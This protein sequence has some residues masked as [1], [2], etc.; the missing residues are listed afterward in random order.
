MKIEQKMEQLKRTLLHSSPY[1][2]WVLMRN[3]TDI[4]IELVKA[5]GGDALD[6]CNV[7]VRQFTDIGIAATEEQL[8]KIM[9]EE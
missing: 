2:E 5:D 9:E 3:A 6:W 8:N 7:W 4:T 1:G